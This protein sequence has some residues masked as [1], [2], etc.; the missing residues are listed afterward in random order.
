MV[1]SNEIKGPVWV[2]TENLSENADV[3][4]LLSTFNRPV[5]VV[6][7]IESVLKQTYEDW[8]LYILDI[9]S[10]PQV[11][12]VLL[13]YQ[14]HQRVC[15]YFSDTQAH[16]RLDRYWLGVMMN[17]GIRKGKEEYIAPLTD[18]CFFLPESLKLKVDYMKENPNMMLCFGGQHMV[19]K[20]GAIL[21][22][23]N[24]FPH[25]T[26]IIRGS[27]QVDLCQTMFR[28]KLVEEAKGFNEDLN[29]KPYPWIDAVMFDEAQNRGYPLYSVG[30]VTDVFIE[31]SKSLMLSLLQ[32]R[33]NE[34][35]SD[36]I[37]E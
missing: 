23:R 2:G 37:W 31:H 9:N 35:L 10:L 17:T 18:D 12:D 30:E 29:K 13:Q 24:L 4:V 3:A 36:A 26:Q 21:R 11:K 27:H 33:R 14:N 8:N 28:R 32:N 1:T 6:K 34:L 5:M 22:T 25:G 16:Q 7:A 19:N 20:E 15:L